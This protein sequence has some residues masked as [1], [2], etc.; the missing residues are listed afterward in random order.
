MTAVDTPTGKSDYRLVMPPL[1]SLQKA[2]RRF[3]ELKSRGIDSFVITKG[4]RARG[5]SLGVS[6]S[7]A[8]ADD[9]L[10]S[11]MGLGYEVLADVIPRVDRGYWVQTREGFFIDEL[12]FDV[13]AEFID[14][15]V[16]E[17]GCMN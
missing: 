16:T 8:A 12:L 5:I 3:R 10:R 9:C 6:S 11:L 7:S 14:V 17:T 13:A 2:F 15:G 1:N 4:L